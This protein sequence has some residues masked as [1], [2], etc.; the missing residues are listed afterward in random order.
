MVEK[1]NGNKLTAASIIWHCM[2]TL[3][4]L[5]AVM[6]GGVQFPSQKDLRFAELIEPFNG[7]L[8]EVEV[9][10]AAN[11]AMSTLS[12]R[13]IIRLE[14]RLDSLD[15]NIERLRNDLAAYNTRLQQILDRMTEQ[16]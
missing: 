6:S 1:L 2:T 3:A 8:R 15:K 12:D 13:A 10:V 16:P 4:M 7:R 14:G 9:K 11:S 5:G